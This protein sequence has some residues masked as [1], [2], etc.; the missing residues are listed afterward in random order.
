MT[1]VFFKAFR[2]QEQRPLEHWSLD[3]YV[4]TSEW[5]Y[6]YFIEQSLLRVHVSDEWTY[7]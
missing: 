2:L 7:P 5:I 3:E 4:H 1:Q 6:E